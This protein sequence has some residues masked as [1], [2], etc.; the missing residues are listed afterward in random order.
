MVLVVVFGSILLLALLL[1]DLAERSILSTCVLFFFGGFLSGEGV[2]GVVHFQPGR[3]VELFL[4]LALFVVL[5]AD[6]MG[7]GIC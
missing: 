3:P 5:Y 4:E 6:G 1:S 2:L 7:I